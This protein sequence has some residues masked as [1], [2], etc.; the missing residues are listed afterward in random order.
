LVGIPDRQKKEQA[1]KAKT[2][3]DSEIFRETFDA[4]E[5]RCVKRILTSEPDQR[6]LREQEY[7]TYRNLKALRSELEKVRGKGEIPN[8]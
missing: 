4:L 2:L 8:G 5:Q 1:A 3:L 7:T 6:D